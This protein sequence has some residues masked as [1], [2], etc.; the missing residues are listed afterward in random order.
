MTFN[1]V[2]NDPCRT[3]AIAAIDI[4]AGMNLELGNTA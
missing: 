3:T 1:V 4:T 2:V